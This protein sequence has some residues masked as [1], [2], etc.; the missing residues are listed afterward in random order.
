VPD[1]P[2]VTGISELVLEVSDLDAA[3]RF[4]GEATGRSTSRYL[5]ALE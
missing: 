5:P 3:R 2:P 4:Y 1:P